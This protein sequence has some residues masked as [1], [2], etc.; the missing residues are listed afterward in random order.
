M[1]LLNEMMRKTPG[2]RN[3]P[4]KLASLLFAILLWV[5]VM[6]VENPEMIKVIKDVEI[7]PVGIERL[8]GRNLTLESR[9]FP[10]VDVTIKGRRSE[11]SAFDKQDVRVSVDVGNLDRG[12]QDVS[13]DKILNAE[14]ISI[15][16]VTLKTVNLEVDKLTEQLKPVEITFKGVAAPGFIPDSAV[17]VPNVISVRGP[18]KL[19]KKVARVVGEVDASTLSA[20]A[21]AQIPV[22]PVSDKGT[23]ISGVQLQTSFVKSVLGLAQM[24]SVP[25]SPTLAGTVPVGYELVDVQMKPSLLTLKGPEDTLK[26]IGILKSR[27]INLSNLTTSVQLPVEV[28]LPKGV[29]L[30]DPMTTLAAEI[31]VE[32]VKTVDFSYSGDEVEYV[33]AAH[34][35]TAKLPAGLKV[36]LRGIESLISGVHKDDIHVKVD[37]LNQAAGK[38]TAAVSYTVS[39]PYDRLQTDPS[40][41]EVEIQ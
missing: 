18:E 15:S 14:N 39:A 41:V 16:A 40:R 4:P 12:V 35:T 36:H 38:T 21:E 5:Y 13:V 2:T 20:K 29:S 3:L 23:T 10:T 6:D 11:V 26:T 30:S 19:V 33:N 27:S 22:H 28:D 7:T 8:E 31:R 34:G 25:I 9:S 17:P 32:A 24:K 1:S 37:L